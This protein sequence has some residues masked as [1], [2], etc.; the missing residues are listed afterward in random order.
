M[1][2]ELKVS[3]YAMA[4]VI[5]GESGFK[6][7]AE[8]V[9]KGVHIAKGLNQFVRS[10][11]VGQ[12]GK[13]GKVTGG[14]MTAE[15]WETYEKLSAQEQLPFVKRFMAGQN[16]AGKNSLQIYARNFGNHNNPDGSMYAGK[17]RQAAW[18]ADHPGAKFN[19][20]QG[21][22]RAIE[23]NASL[24]KGKGY[25][26]IN[27]LG[28]YVA[29]K[30]SAGIRSKIDAAVARAGG[31]VPPTKKVIPPS[32]NANGEW[33][34]KGSANASKSKKEDSKTF[35]N[36]LRDKQAAL[37]E[38][39]LKAQ[40]A[41][42]NATLE[43]INKMKNTPPLRMLVNPSSFKVS[44]EKIIADS[45]W[46]RNGPIIEHWG[47]GQ[48]KLEGSGRVAGFF[49]IDANSPRE[50]VDGQNIGQSLSEGE[51]PGLTRVA[52]NFSASYHNFLSLWL[53]YRNN[54]NII[55]EGD[56]RPRFDGTEWNRISM[57][58][59][60]YIFYDDTIY[61][62]SFDSFNLTETDDKP[63]SL[64]YSFSFTVRATFLL[65]RPYNQQAPGQGA[66]TLQGGPRP[67]GEQE[68]WTSGGGPVTSGL[69]SSEEDINNF[70]AALASGATPPSTAE[71]PAGSFDTASFK[72]GHPTSNIPSRS[73][74]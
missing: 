66:S 51:G 20:P 21:Q 16:V 8:N 27:D 28:K 17:E 37:G 44:S 49:A 69:V 64:E 46:T 67:A 40:Q 38:K 53:L 60:V 14:Y 72:Q 65:D 39:F 56:I 52:R 68:I 2:N 33:V 18:I 31:G 1:C 5:D 55:T 74:P 15:Q 47:E 26:E 43:A 29:G 10:T 50:G 59:S 45:G 24:A 23:Q 25:I 11:A 19:D 9:Q 41:E 4:G 34:D 54:A 61:L 70:K 58:G 35:D 63:Y 12:K 57:V 6:P 62:G 42:I 48:D 3:P 73:K 32:E 13:D 71:K 30:P 22:Q 36:G 7:S